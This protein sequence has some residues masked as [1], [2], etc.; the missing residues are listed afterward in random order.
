MGEDRE[1][2][3]EVL[4]QQALI[5]RAGSQEIIVRRPDKLWKR[6]AKMDV[7]DIKA[8]YAGDPPF[9]DRVRALIE[10]GKG[11]EAARERI[12]S[13]GTRINWEY[14]RWKAQ[15]LGPL[16]RISLINAPDPHL[17]HPLRIV[18][19]ENGGKIPERPEIPRAD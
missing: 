11:D 8:K 9:R 15:L 17:V 7:A 19:R 14:L 10:E 18:Y 5:E 4:K 13:Q 12:K 16:G 1:I 2:D 3:W 6:I